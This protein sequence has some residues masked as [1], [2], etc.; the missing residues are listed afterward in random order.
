MPDL[1]A[2]FHSDLARKSTKE[3]G[4]SGE[5]IAVASD[6]ACAKFSVTL[7]L[8]RRTRYWTNGAMIGSK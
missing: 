5:E 8:T 3:L 2:E 4:A 7:Q 1:E 6:P